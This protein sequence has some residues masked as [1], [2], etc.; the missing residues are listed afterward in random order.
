[1]TTGLTAAAT[2]PT[3]ATTG[4]WHTN[5]ASPALLRAALATYGTAVQR[6]LV[7]AG[8]ADM[9][10]NGP[11]VLGAAGMSGVRLSEVINQ[12][13]LSKQAT[14]QLVDTLVRQGYLRRSVDAND[15]RRLSIVLTKRGQAISAVAK[16]AID[17][18][19]SELSAAVGAD[20]VALTRQAL[21]ALIDL[22]QGP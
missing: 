22:Q 17:R 21:G 7:E 9:P 3:R 4:A 11:L 13:G 20:V 10:R 5:L 16:S 14:G 2:G 1:M 12:L 18:V 15:R 6:S 19:D 8:A